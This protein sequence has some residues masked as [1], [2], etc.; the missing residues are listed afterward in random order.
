MEDDD[1]YVTDTKEDDEIMEDNW[2]EYV[3]H[4]KLVGKSP[5]RNGFWDWYNE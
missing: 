5:S 3:R 2:L 1:F 4:C